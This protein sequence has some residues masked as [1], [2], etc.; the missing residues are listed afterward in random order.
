MVIIKAERSIAAESKKHFSIQ[1]GLYNTE[2]KIFLNGFSMNNVTYDVNFTFEQWTKIGAYS[3]CMEENLNFYLIWKAKILSYCK[4]HSLPPRISC[5]LHENIVSYQEFS[6]NSVGNY[7]SH[8]NYFLC[9]NC[10]MRIILPDFIYDDM[11]GN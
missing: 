9:P 2:Q 3:V 10:G 5:C 11:H 4:E 8:K 7:D 6:V 1:S